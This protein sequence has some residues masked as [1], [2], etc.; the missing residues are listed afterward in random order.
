MGVKSGGKKMTETAKIVDAGIDYIRVTSQDQRCKGRMLDY[1]RAV[2]DRDKKLGYREMTGGAFGFL[3]KKCRHAMYGDKAEWGMV[4]VSGY[5]AKSS[6]RLADEGTQATRIDLQLTYWVGE[7][8]VENVL[9]DAYNRACAAPPTNHRPC[10]VNM[11]E[12]RHRAQTVYI[13][14]RASD[15]FFRIYDKFE[16]S[17]KEE[18]RGCVRFEL[19]LKGRLAKAL[20]QRWVDG[21]GTLYQALEMVVQ[22]LKERGVAVPSEDIDAHDILMLKRPKT[23]EEATLAWLKFQVAPTVKKLTG[24]F[25]WI[26]PFRILFEGACTEWRVRR[27]MTLLAVTWGN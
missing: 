11:I 19:E 3:G 26:T 10:K 18:Y 22:M 21:A 1:Y 7:S 2:R 12:S 14:S 13:G 4:Q 15:I 5:E 8:E 9:R 23:S 17:G 27:I 20:W 25:G 6:L 16:E 24:S